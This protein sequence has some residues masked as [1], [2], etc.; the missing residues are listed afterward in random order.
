MFGGPHEI[1]IAGV[2]FPPELLA[3]VLGVTATGVTAVVLNRYRL[4]RCF[5]YPP[6]VF[7]SLSILYTALIGA[8]WIR[9]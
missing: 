5:V 6:L 3:A 2:Y 4:A 8:V 1:S 7:L 9:F